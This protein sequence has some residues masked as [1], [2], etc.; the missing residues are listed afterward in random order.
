[1]LLIRSYKF[2]A[3]ILVTLVITGTYNACSGFRPLH[4]SSIA[5]KPSVFS[6]G[7]KSIKILPYDVR[8]SKIRALGGPSLQPY[9]LSLL[10]ERKYELGAYNHAA[11]VGVELSWSEARMALWVESIQPICSSG[12]MKS[13]FPWPGAASEFLRA[14][15]G[16]TNNASDSALINQ[17][18]GLSADD[19]QRFEVFCTVVLSSLEFLNL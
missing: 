14:A 19:N 16:R 8:I 18:A 17:V 5:A 13:R 2:I 3:Y 9:H 4:Q 15:Y 11:G 12:E 7:R 1:V 6:I 10:E